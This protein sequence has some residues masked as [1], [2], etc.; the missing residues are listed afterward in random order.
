MTGAAILGTGGGGSPVEGL[1]M[2]KRDLAEG[3]R[4]RIIN[5]KEL[6]ED[7]LVVC[8]YFCGSIAPSA[9]HARKNVVFEDPMKVAF[10]RIQGYL[11]KKA[12]ATIAT[13][14]GGL[15]TAVSLHV[16]SMMDVPLI[17][18]DYIG[19]AAPELIQSSANL[20]GI[21]LY[22]S[23]AV[24]DNG[25]VVLIE[26]YAD[27]A[28]YEE[29]VRSL[30]VAAGRFVA[31]ADTPVSGAVAKRVMIEDT[32]SKCIEVGQ[33]VREANAGG[34]DPIPELTRSLR[35][36]LLFKGNVREFK[37]EDRGGFLFGEAIYEGTR[38]WKGHELKIWIKN[39]NIVAWR[40]EQI[41]A[42]APDLICVT[43]DRGHAITNTE[44]K[45]GMEAVVFGA[46]AP[47]KWLTSKGL[48]LFGP[49]HFGFEFDYMPIVE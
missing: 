10:E 21:P 32:V 24:S 20:F 15:N 34:K 11:G 25:N 47:A 31:V 16:A 6:G 23:V 39:E 26:R 41:V 35:G 9:N 12:S 1:Q 22:P 8:P 14:L 48:E 5:L 30:S 29:I 44:L 4:L 2:L 36:V 28:Q 33:A 3:R 37:W 13:E 19:R 18:G 45:Q 17:D 46:R 40:D 27:L 38:E 43:D 7:A 49:R 42:T